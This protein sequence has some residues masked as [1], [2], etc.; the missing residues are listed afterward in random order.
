[1]A[2]SRLTKDAVRGFFTRNILFAFGHGGDHSGYVD[3]MIG[4]IEFPV[5]A[6]IGAFTPFK[7]VC[8]S[9]PGSKRVFR[10][11]RDEVARE[12]AALGIL[13]ARRGGGRFVFHPIAGAGGLD[14]EM[15]VAGVGQPVK[16]SVL[17]GAYLRQWR[18]ENLC[19]IADSSVPRI[20][21]VL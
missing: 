1:V 20:E 7:P 3:C 14:A 12:F 17:N 6:T 18:Q 5:N 11:Q 21:P 13:R 9:A 19:L 2:L 4:R 15:F 16:G 10:G 8:H